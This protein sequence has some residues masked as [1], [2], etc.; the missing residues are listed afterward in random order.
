[1]LDDP[2]AD[3]LPAGV[4][5]VAQDALECHSSCHSTHPPPR[6]RPSPVC[7]WRW[8]CPAAPD[9]SVLAHR[10]RLVLCTSPSM[11]P[12]LSPPA[13]MPRQARV[14]LSRLPRGTYF[15]ALPCQT[16]IPPTRG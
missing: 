11:S 16:E 9:Q 12:P 15:S 5:I 14:R 6:G 10:L 7:G 1:L 8:R 13:R 4:I 2:I 3:C